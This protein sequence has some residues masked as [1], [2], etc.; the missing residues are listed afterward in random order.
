LKKPAHEPD[1]PLNELE[2]FQKSQQINHDLI[3]Q[4]TEQINA[5]N[6]EQQLAEAQLMASEERFRTL[7]DKAPIGIAIHRNG[8]N[9]FVNQVYVTMHGYESSTKLIGKPVSN[10][11]APEI[12][13]AIVKRIKNREKGEAEPGMYETVGLR[14]DG[15]TFP[16]FVQSTNILLP[17]GPAN[18]TF[19]TDISE[20]KQAQETL[21]KA[22]DE[23]EQKVQER[24]LQLKQKN[25]Q[26]QDTCKETKFDYK[27]ISDLAHDWETWEDEMGRFRLI[28]PACEKISRHTINEFLGNKALF[29]S[30]IVEEDKELW[31]NHRHCIEV[32]KGL[33]NL[34]FRI[35]N[36]SGQIVWIEHICRP[37][38]DENGKNLGYRANNRDITTR[39][40]AEEAL[41]ESE[42][43]YRLL[44]ENAVE[45]IV[46]FQNN[47]VQAC[48]PMA[49]QM[50]GYS[51]TELMALSFIDFVY[52]EDL[53]NVTNRYTMRMQ[54]EGGES[55]IVFR[56][57]KKNKEIIW[58]E[59][60]S[61][62]MHWKGNKALLSFFADITE[63]KNAEEALQSSRRQLSDIIDFLPDATLAIDKE[64][65]V[66]IWNK[67][68]EI[69]TGIPAA[70]M[71][72]KGKY[73]Y[74]I[75]FYGKPRTLLL[76]L[77][78][79]DDKE[80]VRRYPNF[81]R[82]GNAISSEVFCPAL[83]S[84][85]GAWVSIK[86]SP[87]H[88]LAG[89]IVGAIESIR[90]I[91]DQKLVEKEIL[92]LSYH[93]PLTGLYNRRFYEEELTRLDTKRNIPL[94]IIMGD[95]NGLKLI[96]DSFGHAVGDELLKKVA[97]VIR[98]GCREGDIIAR[99][100]GDEFVIVLPKTD[101]F[102]AAKVINRINALLKKEKVES[103]DISISFGHE[104]KSNEKEEIQS[105]YKAAE[106]YMYR[107]KR[108]ENLIMRS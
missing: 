81:S 39:K 29:A 89:N 73:A 32:D 47:K 24:T 13:R 105:I 43:E 91:S 61:V 49:Q 94:T 14:K 23:L 40:L 53:E 71:I 69:M 35:R 56:F 63:R 5:K 78:F 46:V 26:L 85:I 27:I 60:S 12:R 15:S 18:V 55:K 20:R 16:L 101:A 68:I 17:D 88:D 8:I 107:K 22:Y 42:E 1:Q 99:L 104:T 76:D 7:V 50:S 48:N 102:K 28:S 59:S 57:V 52:C 4:L 9:L 83:N 64:R 33:H 106:D 90:D 82:N 30:L 87:L 103:V 2:A 34:Q 66:I 95:V 72:G 62:E 93:D 98:K 38:T 75:P 41:W 11:L 97:D 77:C 65:R 86:A 100:G 51:K 58:V 37:V 25:E 74:S 21:Q 19:L 6:N 80:I 31:A 70:E 67:A 92:F 44:F 96:N 3:N 108:S 79:S 45:A 10:L 54:N 36:K 84:N